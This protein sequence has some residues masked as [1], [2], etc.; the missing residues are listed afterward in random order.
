MSVTAGCVINDTKY[1]SIT[2]TII[3]LHPL[4]SKVSRNTI[5]RLPRKNA[6]HIV[7]SAHFLPAFRSPPDATKICQGSK[8]YLTFTAREVGSNRVISSWIIEKRSAET[9][10]RVSPTGI[11]RVR[12]SGSENPERGRREAT[13]RKRETH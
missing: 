1:Q 2:F 7:I 4:Q 11:P 10:A 13:R 9:L 3:Y 8:I 5:E 12:G 6:E